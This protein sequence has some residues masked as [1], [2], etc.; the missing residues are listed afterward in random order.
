M[1]ASSKNTLAGREI[2]GADIA[3]VTAFLCSEDASMIKGQI[4]IV[5]GGITLQAPL[6]SANS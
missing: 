4:I 3:K 5:D 6:S 1:V 2:T